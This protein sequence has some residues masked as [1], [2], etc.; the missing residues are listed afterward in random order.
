MLYYLVHACY[1]S[2][3]S[4]FSSFIIHDTPPHL[5]EGEKRKERPIVFGFFFS[6]EEE[7]HYIPPHCMEAIERSFFYSSFAHVWMNGWMKERIWWLYD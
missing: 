3:V 1:I 2:F 4:S 7:Q 5:N 6:V